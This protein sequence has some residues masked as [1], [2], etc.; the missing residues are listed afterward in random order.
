VKGRPEI[1]VLALWLIAIL[2]SAVLLDASGPFTYLG[3]VQ[4]VCMLGSVLA[5]RKAR[6]SRS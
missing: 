4:F 6:Q 2:S 3:P 1:A 5:V